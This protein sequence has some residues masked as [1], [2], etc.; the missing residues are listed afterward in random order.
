MNNKLITALEDCLRS[1]QNGAS[2]EDALRRY[3][4]LSAELRP[5]LHYGASRPKG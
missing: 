4:D 5:L 3:P 1:L 2:L